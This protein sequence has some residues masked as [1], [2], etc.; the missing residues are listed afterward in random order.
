MATLPGLHPAPRTH[1]AG[2]AKG[3]R[4]G[5]KQMGPGGR[6]DSKAAQRH[7]VT[8]GLI[9][10]SWCPEDRLAPNSALG[11]GPPR[12]QRAA[13]LV[14]GGTRPAT[15]ADGVQKCFWAFG[16]KTC[17]PGQ[18][19]SVPRPSLSDAHLADPTKPGE[20]LPPCPFGA[21]RWGS[22]GREPFQGGRPLEK[23]GRLP[24]LLLSAPSEPPPAE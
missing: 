21:Q 20:A 12:L 13:D 11:Q 1:T 2:A 24:S 22:I 10:H 9:P 15:P 5:R 17:S 14:L 19:I 16:W 8:C 23:G 7:K 6:K 3:L 4:A 18:G